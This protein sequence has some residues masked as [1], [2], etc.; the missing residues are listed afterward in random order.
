MHA[1]AH[2]SDSVPIG[3]KAAASAVTNGTSSQ[4]EEKPDDRDQ[5][6]D[7]KDDEEAAPGDANGNAGKK[8]VFSFKS[9]LLRS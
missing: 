5:S 8:M 6:D 2:P 3:Q 7:D 4:E 9:V 1:H